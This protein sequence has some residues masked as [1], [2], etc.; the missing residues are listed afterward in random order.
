MTFAVEMT[1]YGNV[2]VSIKESGPVCSGVAKLD[3]VLCRTQW[4]LDFY[5]GPES[6]AMICTAII[7]QIILKV[8]RSGMKM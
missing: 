6:I 2:N 3:P 1:E 7:G 5:I 4:S 8:P